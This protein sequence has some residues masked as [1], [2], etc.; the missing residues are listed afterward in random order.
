MGFTIRVAS[1]S[2]K[3]STSKLGDF[4]IWWTGPPDGVCGFRVAS[5]LECFA[6]DS[7]FLCR[8]RGHWFAGFRVGMLRLV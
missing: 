7:G 4:S 1:L 8:L 3:P 6:F 5:I 2:P